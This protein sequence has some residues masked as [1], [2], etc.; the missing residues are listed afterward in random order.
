MSI[1]YPSAPEPAV[2]C[3]ARDVLLEII[4]P[5]ALVQPSRRIAAARMRAYLLQR[6]GPRPKLEDGGFGTNDND[7]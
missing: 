5:E 1:V 6:N 7:R 3:T 4:A 2:L